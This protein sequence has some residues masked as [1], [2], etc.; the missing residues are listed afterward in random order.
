MTGA[1]KQPDHRLDTPAKVTGSSLLQKWRAMV[2][3][4]FQLSA[5]RK[6]DAGEVI[7]Y[8]VFEVLMKDGGKC[9]GCG[10][11]EGCGID[12]ICSKGLYWAHNC[13]CVLCNRVL[14]TF[15]WRLE[16]STGEK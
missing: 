15:V 6:I 4:H 8:G 10:A 7:P 13:W 2:D 9:N 3:R 11:T 5:E 16:K 14:C 1:I 12:R